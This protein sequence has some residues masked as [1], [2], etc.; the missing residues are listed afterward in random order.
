MPTPNH[1]P[2]DS[3][4]SIWLRLH[5]TPRWPHSS[6]WP[7]SSSPSFQILVRDP[8]NPTSHP[9]CQLAPFSRHPAVTYAVCA[10]TSHLPR[11]MGID[12]R[13]RPRDARQAQQHVR[14]SQA[15]YRTSGQTRS[16]YQIT[17]PQAY[18]APHIS[19]PKPI[20]NRFS[21]GPQHRHGPSMPQ[22]CPRTS[23]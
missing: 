22:S 7:H 2:H 18:R 12:R 19:D 20:P 6:P 15:R 8:C 17:R 14:T 16:T 10:N 1:W 13:R 4:R 5:S 9:W 3:T 21:A 23:R 11:P